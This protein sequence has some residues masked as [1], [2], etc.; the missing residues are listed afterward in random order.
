[1]T[2][3]TNIKEDKFLKEVLIEDCHYEGLSLSDAPEA[4]ACKGDQKRA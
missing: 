2:F 4:M 1:L 3:Y